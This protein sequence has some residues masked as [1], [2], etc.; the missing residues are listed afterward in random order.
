MRLPLILSV[1]K[2]ED[3]NVARSA[4]LL[5]KHPLQGKLPP[6]EVGPQM[7]VQSNVQLKTKNTKNSKI[8]EK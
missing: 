4:K 6:T 3:P 8:A 1:L 7:Y 2:A 5:S